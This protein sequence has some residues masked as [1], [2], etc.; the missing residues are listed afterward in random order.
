MPEVKTQTQVPQD[1]PEAPGPFASD[2]VIPTLIMIAIAILSG[3]MNFMQKVKAGQARW[4][5][6]TELVGELFTSAICGLL[7]YWLFKGFGLNEW[8]TAAG[9]GIVGH[10]GSRALFLFEQY[11][12]QLVEKKLGVTSPPATNTGETHG[13]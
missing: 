2:Q 5:N 8:W 11:G 1:A 10:M 6:L 12:T 13:T 3:V 7:A 9:V 4:M